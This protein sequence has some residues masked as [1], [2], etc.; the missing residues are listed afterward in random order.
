VDEPVAAVV[1]GT[2]CGVGHW[3]SLPEIRPGLA[4]WPSRSM[5]I[6]G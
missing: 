3:H 6:T 2:A 1:M 4:S 5:K